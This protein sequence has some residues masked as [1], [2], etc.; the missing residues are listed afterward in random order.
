MPERITHPELPDNIVV[1]FEFL[2]VSEIKLQS[3]SFEMHHGSR[4]IKKMT[5]KWFEN[6]TPEIHTPKNEKPTLFL[7]DKEYSVSFSHTKYAIS[8]AI[9]GQYNVGCDMES[10]ER[11]VA[12]SLISRMKHTGE[13][14]DLYVTNPAI[15][16]WTLKE[17]ALK[18]AGTGLRQPMNSI[19]VTAL[20][21]NLFGV[22]FFDGIRAKICSFQHQEHWIS[23]C[24]Q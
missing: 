20:G 15:K 4:F 23:I 5:K 10:I 2:R 19:R 16:V 13:A 24:F 18:M 9:S 22:E 21:N 7:G 1:C 14:S 11:E 17:S 12:T 3:E 8:S 6:R